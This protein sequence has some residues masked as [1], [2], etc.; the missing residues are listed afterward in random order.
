MKI[1]LLFNTGRGLTSAGAQRNRTQRELAQVWLQ[2]GAI[3]LG[4]GLYDISAFSEEEKEKWGRGARDH[5]R[6]YRVVK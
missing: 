6:S 4:D 1:Q 5:Q 2:K 3:H